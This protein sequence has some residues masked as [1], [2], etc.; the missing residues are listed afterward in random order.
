MYFGKITGQSSTEFLILAAGIL[1]ISTS[2]FYWSL[3]NHEV[4]T[5][6]QATRDGAENALANIEINYGV[7]ANIEYLKLDDNQIEISIAIMG[8]PPEIAWADF[9]ENVVKKTVRESVFCHIQYALSSLSTK[10]PE[11][12]PY[13]Y[14]VSVSLRKVI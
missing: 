4:T 7:S 12:A 5:I 14:D 2:F 6:I 9:A 13:T 11:S 3:E 8:T 1:L 10:N